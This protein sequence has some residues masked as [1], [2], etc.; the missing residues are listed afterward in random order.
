[1]HTHSFTQLHMIFCSSLQR[2]KS[3][4]FF[5]YHGWIEHS[6][7]P[8]KNHRVSGPRSVSVW[9]DWPKVTDD[10]WP[11]RRPLNPI[12]EN[13]FVCFIKIRRI[14]TIFE[15][16]TYWIYYH[17]HVV[18]FGVFFFVCGG[19]GTIWI[20]LKSRK[21]LDGSLRN[22]KIRKVNYLQKLKRLLQITGNRM[23]RFFNY[24]I[25][26]KLKCTF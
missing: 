24:Y 19:G 16:K 9:R 7:Y 23:I 13:L 8:R 1:M 26:W 5:F 21:W 2:L 14:V 15:N 20:W 11:P 6:K 12:N 3:F 18:V 25:I 17:L 22:G 10:V 4:C